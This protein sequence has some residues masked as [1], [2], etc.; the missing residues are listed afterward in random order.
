VA[1]KTQHQYPPND[2]LLELVREHG[3]VRAVAAVIGVSTATLQ[4]HLSIQPPPFPDRLAAARGAFH[5]KRATPAG[6][7]VD[8]DG[9]A[10]GDVR[11]MLEKRGLNPEEW[12]VRGARVNEWGKGTCTNC[13]HE[14]APLTQLRVDLDPAA[15]VIMPARTEGWKPPKLKPKQPKREEQLVVFLS[16]QHAPHHDP[17]LHEAV[18]CWLQTIKPDL[19]VLLGDLVDNDSVSRHR[20]NP[21][22]ATT[23]ND[24]YT[25]GWRLAADYR[26]AAPSATFKAVDGNHEDR[27][28][29][30]VLDNL[31]GLAGFTRPGD[32][33]PVLSTPHLLRFDELDID[34][35][36]SQD[37]YSHHAVKIGETLS[38]CHGWVAKRG[39]GASALA[40][41]QIVRHHVAIGHVHRQG[42]V[43]HTHH[44]ID[45]E[46]V[47]LHACEVGTLATTRGGLG[48]VD[49]G[50]ADWQQGAATASVWKDGT[51]DFDLARWTGRHLSWRGERHAAG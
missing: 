32:K 29:N 28:R 50:R 22:W 2:E 49:G 34:F 24:C 13:E 14:V 33:Y 21:A 43:S 6:N 12:A 37:T 30:G 16:D 15:G 19:V 23:L 18:C 31:P 20:K 48:Y 42:I 9:V 51:V 45:G 47:T 38:G 10:L 36:G 26:S 3:T 8:M 35:V 4:S 25:A 46:P 1:G 41:L 17:K 7:S 11:E 27:L 39:A 40:T 5:S 44:T